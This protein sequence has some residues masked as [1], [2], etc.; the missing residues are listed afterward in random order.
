MGGRGRQHGIDERLEIISLVEEAQKAGARQKMACKVLNISCRTLMRWKEADGGE[1]GRNGPKSAPANKLSDMERKRILKVVNS[2]VHRDSSPNQIVPKL[3]D[4]GIYIASESTI[5][6][7][8]RDKDQLAHRN[9]ARPAESS[10]PKE[11]VATGP[12]QVWSWDIT[13]LPAP[14]KGTFF[15]LYMIV[16][17]WSRMIVGWEVNSRECMEISAQF[18]SGVCKEHG[19]ENQSLALHSDNGGPMKGATMLAMLHSLGIAAS[20]SRPGVSDD[21]PFSEALFKTLKYRPEYP[22]KPFSSI[23]AAQEWVSMFVHWYNNE[24]RHSAIKFT[25]PAQRHYGQDIEILQNRKAT[26][27]A[28]KKKNPNRWPGKTRNW[29]R[30]ETVIL[31]PEKAAKKD[32]A[33]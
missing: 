25:T 7:V 13:Y 31:N 32:L 6:R 26:Y 28:A 27:Q 30:I 29:D 21:N 11:L 16:D 22:P 3:A 12:N 24:H 23:E 10:P 18:M 2:K 20:F 19:I 14:I 4:D 8:L 9:K 17:V 15:Y 5:Y 33:C 1:D